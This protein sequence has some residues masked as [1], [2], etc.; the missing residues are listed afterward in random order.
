MISKIYAD[1]FRGLINFELRL[2]EKNLLLGPN[3]SGKTTVFDLLWRIQRLVVGGTKVA[4]VFSSGH[5]CPTKDGLI[6]CKLFGA[7]VLCS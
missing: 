7:M 1:N 6:L 5:W 4:E 3:G 2:G